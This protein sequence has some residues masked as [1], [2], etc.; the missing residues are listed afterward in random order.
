M[1][2]IQAKS[3]SICLEEGSLYP[4]EAAFNGSCQFFLKASLHWPIRV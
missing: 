4:N 2:P 3:S 1:G